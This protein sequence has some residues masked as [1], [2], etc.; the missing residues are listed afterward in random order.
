MVF[1]EVIKD[2]LTSRASIRKLKRPPTL[3]SLVA[4]G[5]C[6]SGLAAYQRVICSGDVQTFQILA[7]GALT[8]TSTLTVISR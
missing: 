1:Q 7:S 8:R 5:A 2:G 3:T 4:R 6:Q